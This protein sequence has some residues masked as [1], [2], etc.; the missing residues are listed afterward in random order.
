[1]RPSCTFQNTIYDRKEQKI[2]KEVVSSQNNKMNLVLGVF[3]ICS[4]RLC[5][6]RCVLSFLEGD[7]TSI[8]V[9][10]C[11]CENDLEKG[12]NCICVPE[13]E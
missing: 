6:L 12:I 5:I 7:S 3:C 9:I 1:M 10:L 2:G 4:T 11:Q 8:A 13:I